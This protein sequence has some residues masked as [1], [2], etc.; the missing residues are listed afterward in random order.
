MD[1]TSGAAEA[2]LA[3]GLP[4]SI[5]TA[6]VNGVQNLPDSK[7]RSDRSAEEITT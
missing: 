7:A 2:R 5:P 6:C 1:T 4:S 3:T